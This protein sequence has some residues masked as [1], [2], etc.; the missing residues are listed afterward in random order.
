MKPREYQVAA[1]DALW[2]SL[3]A[4]PTENPLAVMPTGSGKS[5]TIAML[6]AG[7]IQ[8]YP[9]VRILSV[10]HVKELVAG[11]H[12]TLM[13]YMP[14]AP[15]GVYSAGLGRRDTHAPITFAGIDSVAGKEK[16]FGKIDFLLV[17][18]AH[19]I[20]D[21]ET[22]NYQKLI[23]KLREVNPALVVIGFTAT[24][25]RLGMGKLTEGGLFDKVAFDLSSG[26]A[27]VWL[28]RQGYLIKPVPKQPSVQVDSSRVGIQMGEFK[29]K[30]AA[31]AFDEQDIL[32]QAVDEIILR[33]NAEK[34]RAWLTFAQS[35]EHTEQL[36]DM[37][38]SKGYAVEAVHSKR[39]DRDEV[40]AAF[41]KGELL[42]VVNK[43]ILTTGYDNVNI[44]LM[45]ILRLTN[46]PGLWVQMLGRGTRPAFVPGYDLTTA[47]GRLASIAA[48]HKQNC[49]VLDFAGNSERLG[50]I[51]YPTIPKRRGAGGG[52]PP[53]R[54]CPECGTYNHI[55]LKQ[56]E[57]CGYAFPVEV[58]LKSKSAEKEL[59]LDLTQPIQPTPAPE[60]VY[61]IFGVSQ[62]VAAVHAG[63]AVAGVQKPDSLKID[64]FSGVRRFSLW[65]CFDHPAG[66]FP[67]RRAAD[68]WR[69][70]APTKGAPVPASVVEA[71]ARFP[72]CRVPKYIKV[73]LNTKYPEVVAY[74]FAGTAFQLPPELGGGLPDNVI[75]V[76]TPIGPPPTP[77]PL[78]SGDVQGVPAKEEVDY[79]EYF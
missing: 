47:E 45:A 34:R 51:N 56:C 72:D 73:W 28:I 55:S 12:R 52:P 61:G 43:D 67:Q 50:P 15:A 49:L 78:P 46:S 69:M 23:A 66:G 29:D 74:D 2:G 54:V 57:E 32:E 25:Y 58:K 36:A 75:G 21:K 16:L 10:V 60:K 40:L 22:S 8:V 38:K 62:M 42:G 1:A 13:R 17:D 14:T 30:D 24:D 65:A 70:H 79:S 48:S 31:R 7:L 19:R 5:L 53:S 77:D 18:E 41:E 76:E 64:Y 20:G 33:G 71:L 26:E 35:I 3:H 44:D 4:A 27:F 6:I 11:N 9:W 68:W 63:K 37:F 39:S 59:V